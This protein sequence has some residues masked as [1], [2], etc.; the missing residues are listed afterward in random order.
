M[1]LEKKNAVIY[2]AGGAIGSALARAFAREGARVVLA[3]RTTGPLA[4]LAKEISAAGG[5]VETAQVDAL[6]EESVEQQA[7]ALARK[8][9][10]I[11]VSFNV[12]SVPHVQGRP[13][14]DLSVDDFAAPIMSYAKTHFLTARAAARHMAP[15]RS[16]AILMM[17][18][19]PDRRAIPMVGPFGTACAAIEAFA[20]TLAAEVGPKGIRVVCLRSTGSPETPGV[21]R[22]FADHA[23]ANGVAPKE[24][25]ENYKRQTMLRR[26]TTLEELTNMAVFLASDRASAVTGT[27]VNLTCGAIAD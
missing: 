22:A 3:G 8:V 10:S 18:T 1:L 5:A 21:Q 19:T 16:G 17:T 9:G 6:N 26:L 15:K 14:V 4:A 13:L 12:I 25:L 2:G 27:A 20:H 11:D 24:W 7:A 23:K